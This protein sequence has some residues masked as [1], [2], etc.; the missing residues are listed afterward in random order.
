MQ[1]HATDESPSGKR[2]NQDL[3]HTFLFFQYDHVIVFPQCQDKKPHLSPSSDLEAECR[4]LGNYHLILWLFAEIKQRLVTAVINLRDLKYIKSQVPSSF[5]MITVSLYIIFILHERRKYV[6]LLTLHHRKLNN[7]NWKFR[8]C[9]VQIFI[10][11]FFSQFSQF[12]IFIALFWYSK[13]QDLDK[14]SE[15][16]D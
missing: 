10:L 4:S 16:L 6:K 11:A 9:W 14:P 7:V 8:Q 15:V 1:L 12:M 5:V 2:C 3:R 13:Q